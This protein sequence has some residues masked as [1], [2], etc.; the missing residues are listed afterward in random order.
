[1]WNIINFIEITRIWN[2]HFEVVKGASGAQ[3]RN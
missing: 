3:R 2:K 1:V